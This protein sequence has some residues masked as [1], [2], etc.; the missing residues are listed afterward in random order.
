M[1]IFYDLRRS[2]I[3]NLIRA[4]VSQQ[5]AMAWSGHLSASVFARYDITSKDDLHDAAQKLQEYMESQNPTPKKKVQ[6]ITD[7]KR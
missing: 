2:G 1:R 3:R 5:V 6:A 7:K 4:G